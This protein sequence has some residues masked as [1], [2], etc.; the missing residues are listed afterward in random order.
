MTLALST[1]NAL[2]QTNKC[3]CLPV[4]LL[5][6]CNEEDNVVSDSVNIEE[7]LF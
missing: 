6:I 2:S 5:T 4:S 3:S 1:N 7:T